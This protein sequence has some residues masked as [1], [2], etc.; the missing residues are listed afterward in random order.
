[1]RIAEDRLEGLDR[2]RAVLL[3]GDAGDDEPE[4]EAG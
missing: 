4:P 1:M 2:P 3:E